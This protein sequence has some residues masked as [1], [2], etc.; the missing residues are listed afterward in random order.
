MTKNLVNKIVNY[1]DAGAALANAGAVYATAYAIDIGVNAILRFNLNEYNSI[2]HLAAGTIIGTYAYRRVKDIVSEQTGSKLKG[3]LAGLG[4]GLLAGGII[5][6]SWE[7][8]EDKG[9]IF[10]NG[11]VPLDTMLDHVAIGAGVV[12]SPL[13][14]LVK[15]SIKKSIDKF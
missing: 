10:K 14:E 1:E 9:K 11:E 12:L 8:V 3:A 13:M 15:P 2:L 6:L 7:Y 5:S 4:A